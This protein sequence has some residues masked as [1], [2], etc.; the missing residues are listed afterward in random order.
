MLT[1]EP[2]F[3][4]EDFILDKSNLPNKMYIAS[5]QGILLRSVPVKG[6]RNPRKKLSD[7]DILDDLNWRSQHKHALT[8]AYNHSPYFE[9]YKHEL[10]DLLEKNYTSLLELNKNTMIWVSKALKVTLDIVPTTYQ[11]CNPGHVFQD[12][13]EQNLKN[14]PYRQVFEEQIGFLPNLCVLDV[15][16]NLARHSK[17]Y[18]IEAYNA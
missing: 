9:F 5:S 18:L 15:L 13:K 3:V 4:I 10:F 6:G 14:S 1:Q 2:N 8:A 7:I 11:N 17:S 16:F 12:K